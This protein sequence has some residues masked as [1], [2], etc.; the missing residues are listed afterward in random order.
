MFPLRR[1][2]GERLASSAQRSRAVGV[3]TGG[4]QVGR[5]T[6]PSYR[7]TAGLRY[8]PHNRTVIMMEGQLRLDIQGET[9]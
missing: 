7:K 6:A 1:A 3:V 8:I 2:W 9:R 4:T 5:S